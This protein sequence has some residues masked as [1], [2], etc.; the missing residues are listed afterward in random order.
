MNYFI[1]SVVAFCPHPQGLSVGVLSR[2]I[3]DFTLI[4]IGLYLSLPVVGSH[5]QSNSGGN[6]KDGRG[7]LTIH[8]PVKAGLIWT[9]CYLACPTNTILYPFQRRRLN[10]WPEGSED[11]MPR[12]IFYRFIHWF[13]WTGLISGSYCMWKEVK[14]DLILRGITYNPL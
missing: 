9:S 3:P 12:I 4:M 8:Y 14:M 6:S 2:F 11:A 10:T 1:E 7:T 5:F 13:L